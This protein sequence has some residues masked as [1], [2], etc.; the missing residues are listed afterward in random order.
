MTPNERSKR[1]IVRKIHTLEKELGQC[2]EAGAISK[3]ALDALTE[4]IEDLCL[5]LSSITEPRVSAYVVGYRVYLID[6]S[7]GTPHITSTRAVFL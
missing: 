3:V 5:E 6:K 1:A 2:G 7:E 4:E